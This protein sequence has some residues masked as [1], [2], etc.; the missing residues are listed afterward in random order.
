MHRP[1]L[2]PGIETCA[3]GREEPAKAEIMRS[4]TRV[5]LSMLPAATALSPSTAACVPNVLVR[6]NAPVRPAASTTS[7][8]KLSASQ[9][10]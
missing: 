10:A 8:W 2:A 4:G 9:P 1:F 3:H 5:L 6:E 7:W